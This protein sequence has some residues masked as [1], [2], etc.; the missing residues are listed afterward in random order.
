[1][2]RVLFTEMQI[3]SRG[4]QCDYCLMD[5][6]QFFQFVSICQFLHNYIFVFSLDFPLNQLLYCM[7]S[8]INE[9]N[10]I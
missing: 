5:I 4:M 6:D 10:K 3:L 1:M 9:L 7:N 2:Q 8:L